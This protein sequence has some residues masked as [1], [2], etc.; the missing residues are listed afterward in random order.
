MMLDNG[1]PDHWGQE[2]MILPVGASSF[3]EAMIIGADAGQTLSRVKPWV[4][5]VVAMVNGW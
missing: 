2:F 3:K 5:A 4:K 1:Y